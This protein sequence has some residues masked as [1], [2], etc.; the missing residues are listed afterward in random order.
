VVLEN[1]YDE[2]SFVAAGPSVAKQPNLPGAPLILL[3]SGIVYPSERDPTC[4]F[5]ALGRLTLERRLARSPLERNHCLLRGERATG[6]C[7]CIW[8]SPGFHFA[9]NADWIAW[10][11][12]WFLGWTF[13]FSTSARS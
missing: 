11:A 2:E 9:V 12:V 7:G 5:Q 3:H 13:R 6:S 10:S 8:R 1:G 4:L